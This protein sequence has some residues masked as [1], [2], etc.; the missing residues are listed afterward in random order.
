MTLVKTSSAVALKK[1]Q[2]RMGSLAEGEPHAPMS[3]QTQGTQAT[4]TDIGSDHDDDVVEVP[5]PHGAVR[6]LAYPATRVAVGVSAE[7]QVE[8]I[9]KVKDLRETLGKTQ[10]ALY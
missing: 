4:S 8:F 10:N 7:S 3:F 6:S 5:S 1:G 2:R 9:K